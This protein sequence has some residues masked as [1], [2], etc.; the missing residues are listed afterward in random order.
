MKI[1]F[2]CLFFL[3]SIISQAQNL[4]DRGFLLIGKK[5]QKDYIGIRFGGIASTF[6]EKNN[7]SIPSLG[8]SS[9]KSWH[10]GI[11]CDMFTQKYYNAR[12]ELSYLTKGAK[13][14]FGNERVAIQSINKLHYLQLSAIPV[15]IKPGFRK[16]NPYLA[17]GGYY[18][19]RLGINSRMSV[20]NGPWE[21]DDFTAA[22]L[23]RKNDYGYSVS[24]GVYVWRRPL[25]ELRYEAGIPSV[26]STSN[27]KNRSI[28]LSFS[29]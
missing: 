2:T 3:A 21:A 28:A 13:E 16:I 11:S 15:V 14:T 6:A 4:A 27:I 5:P 24:V 7:L 29:I 12:L 22:N 20:D 1:I 8:S 23:N 25:L 18:A 17:L 10:A 26:S 19:Q 9:L